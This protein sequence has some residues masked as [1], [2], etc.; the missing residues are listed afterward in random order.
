LRNGPP[1]L[2]SGIIYLR[3]MFPQMRKKGLGKK[4]DLRQGGGGTGKKKEPDLGGENVHFKKKELPRKVHR[5]LFFWKRGTQKTERKKEKFQRGPSFREVQ[6]KS[7]SGPPTE[8]K[9]NCAYPL[10]LIFLPRGI[11]WPR[12]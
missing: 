3:E 4:V 2:K 1:S 8:E 7:T 10:V 9:D 12:A 6:S 5:L 11:S